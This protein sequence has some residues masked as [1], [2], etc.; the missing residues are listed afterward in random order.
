MGRTPAPPSLPVQESVLHQLGITDHDLPRRLARL[1][2]NLLLQSQK[3]NICAN[4]DFRGPRDPNEYIDTRPQELRQRLNGIIAKSP[5]HPD[6]NETF[7]SVSYLDQIALVCLAAGWR[8]C[9]A[10]DCSQYRM[11]LERV[12]PVCD[13][14]PGLR[15][16]VLCII[17]CSMSTAESQDIEDRYGLLDSWE[18]NLLVRCRDHLTACIILTLPYIPE[19]GDEWDITGRLVELRSPTGTDEGGSIGGPRP[20]PRVSSK[21]CPVLPLDF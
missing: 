14:W 6:P 21:R 19:L 4:S 18:D 3:S 11:L 10:R 7:K 17:S 12:V 13:S 20:G 15:N 16:W 5:S 8:D 2:D 9:R 1:K